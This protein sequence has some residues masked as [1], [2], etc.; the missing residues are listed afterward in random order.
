MPIDKASDRRK[1]PELRQFS[2]RMTLFFIWL[3]VLNIFV[4]QIPR[5]LEVPYSTFITQVEADRVATAI[6][7]PTQI[8]Y[9]L[10]PAP[11]DSKTMTCPSNPGK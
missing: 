10:N 7:S 9:E 6:I 5:D 1:Q 2:G 4:F 3:A 8:Q 11:A